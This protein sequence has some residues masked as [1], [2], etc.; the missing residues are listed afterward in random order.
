MI[1]EVID[2]SKKIFDQYEIYSIT[3]ENHPISFE[4]NKLKEI[5]KKQTSG[6]AMRGIKNNRIGLSSTTNPLKFGQLIENV[7][8][9]STYGSKT[10]MVFPSDTIY[11]NIPIFDKSLSLVSEDKIIENIKSFIDKLLSISSNILVDSKIG[12]V[13]GN[14]RIINS[15]GFDNNYDY[16]E[17]YFY[18]N[19]N[20]IRGDDMLNVWN[21]CSSRTMLSESELDKSF[22]KIKRNLEWA[23]NTSKSVNSK[24]E[25]PVIFTPEGFLSTFLGPLLEGFNGKNFLNKTSPIIN[26]LGK[27]YLDKKLSI[28]DNPHS[29]ELTGSKPFDDEGT[30][31]R[32]VNFVQNGILGEPYYDLQ[33]ASQLNLNS[34]G[35]GGRSIST[36]LYPSISNIEIDNGDENF[37][38]LISTVKDG[39]IVDS[40]LGAGQG[41]ELG[42]EFKANLS[43]GY[44]IING[45]IVG[46]VK[47]TMISGNVYE[48]L[49]RIESISKDVENVYGSAKI[50]AI[51][52]TGVNVAS[53]N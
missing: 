27:Q 51:K 21:G 8:N 17:S 20:L 38:D 2:K 22:F 25:L 41:N 1:N 45:E 3:S 19:A 31:T 50:P 11:N 18:A 10:K 9:L 42:G 44:R 36:N 35:S 12:W 28:R 33:T 48:C 7:K 46:R 43:L 24:G 39:I 32:V 40:L 5:T 30:P 29:N 53:S 26:L 16:S 4:S 47:D 23:K 6:F 34:S 49:S 37:S 14:T 15:S 52:C 13:T